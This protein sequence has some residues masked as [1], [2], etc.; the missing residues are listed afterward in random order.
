VLLK[1][2]G[3]PPEIADVAVFLASD[4]S[5]YMTG[6]VLVADGGATAWYGL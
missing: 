2:I 6:A 4:R 3:R 5:S 1:R